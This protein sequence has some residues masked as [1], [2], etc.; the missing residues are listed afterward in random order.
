MEHWLNSSFRVVPI[1][2]C[3]PPSLPFSIFS[4]PSLLY[5]SSLTPTQIPDLPATLNHVVCPSSLHQTCSRGTHH[6]YRPII[7]SHAHMFADFVMAVTVA[8][9][10]SP[11]YQH[12]WWWWMGSFPYFQCLDTI[13]AWFEWATV[14]CQKV[15]VHFLSVHV[16]SAHSFHQG[17]FA[18]GIRWWGHSETTRTALQV[19][20]SL[21]LFFSLIIC[22]RCCFL[23]DWLVSSWTDSSHWRWC[24]VLK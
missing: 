15:H 23:Q 13:Y 21:P 5:C 14:P 22:I 24:L 1:S 19:A 4:S 3:H 17:Y 10:L 16:C 11:P 6:Y 9:F 8:F 20:S 7:M 12:W 2:H 18:L